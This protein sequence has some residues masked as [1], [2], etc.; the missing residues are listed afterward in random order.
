MPKVRFETGQV[1]NFDSMPS[2][3]DIDEVAS[4]LGIGQKQE[5]PSR[6]GFAENITQH[7]IRSIFRPV[8]ETMGLPTATE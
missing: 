1:V 3:S 4:K 6:P 5:K 8:S 2:Q 7:P